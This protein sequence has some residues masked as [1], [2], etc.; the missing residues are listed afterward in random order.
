MREYDNPP[1]RRFWNIGTL[2]SMRHRNFRLLLYGAFVSAAGDFMQN[3]AQSWLVWQLTRSPVLLGV[4]GFFDTVP[5]L[6][7][8]AFGGAIADR[9]DRR[10]LLML[11]QA[12]GMVQAFIYWF[13]VYFQFIAFWHIAVLAFFL[14]AVNT[15]NQLA[16]QSLVNSLVPPEELMNAIG[17]QS[18]VFNLS[19]IVGPSAGGILI[20]LAGVSGCFFLNALSFLG[21]IGMLVMMELPP[22]EK[23]ENKHGLLNEIREGFQY[24]NSNRRLFWIIA[25]SYVIALVGAPY[26]RFLPMVATNI[27]HI[28]PTGFGALVAAPGVGA[29]FAALTLASLRGTRPSLLMICSCALAFGIVLGLFAFSHSFAF[30]LFMLALTG[31]FFIAF[32]AS[33]NT[34]I[35]S[36]TPRHLLGRVLSLFFMD[37][38]LWSLGGIMIGSSAAVIGIDHTLAVCALLCA[39][40]AAGLLFVTGRPA[41]A[42]L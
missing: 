15:V 30:S 38:G 16:R 7:F 32:R 6:M 3:I 31:F 11:T 23:P 1:R 17:L 35:Q 34:A 25:L 22:W 8:G 21:L 26:Q 28:G 40:A 27:L 33:S 13:L 29:T 9:M 20:A 39:L 14:G 24:L 2:R 36:D 42:R 37:R 19:K 41:G 5:R 4:V 12:L 18:S 10:R